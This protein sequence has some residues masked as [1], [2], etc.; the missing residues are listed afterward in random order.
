MIHQPVFRTS[1]EHTEH[2]NP[3]LISHYQGNRETKQT[4]RGWLLLFVISLFLTGCQ[5]LSPWSK[6][7]HTPPP[8][9]TVETLPQPSDKPR[10][11]PSRP[12]TVKR[13]VDFP[14]AEY[15]SLKKTGNAAIKGR[16]GNGSLPAG[17]SRRVSIAPVTSYSAEAAE[18]ALSGKPIESPDPRAQA[19]THYANVDANG[20]FSISGLA[21][22]DYYVAGNLGN[23]VVISQVRAR[24]GRTVSVILGR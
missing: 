19:Y 17:S 24:S 21:A 2:M 15:A 23:K 22:G 13:D 16:L 1:I 4:M 8:P 20:N 9:P 12:D 14:E 6:D 3:F 7:T 11:A 18:I 5:A 10:P